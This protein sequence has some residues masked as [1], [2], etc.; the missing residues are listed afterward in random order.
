MDKVIIRNLKE[1]DEK[2]LML[3]YNSLVKE[4]A[5]TVAVRKVSFK[6]EREYVLKSVEDQKKKL[7]VDLVLEIN[8]RVVGVAG[9]EVKNREI[10]NHVGN[11]GIL[12]KKE[13]RGKGFG[14]KLSSSV[15]SEAKKK[16]K[17]KMVRLNVSHRNK[18][19]IKLY[20]KLGFKYVGTIKKGL[21]FFGR[22]D[23]DVLMVKHF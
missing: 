9:V 12:L 2:D 22:Y 23:D 18:I 13:A 19:A 7:V 15:I 4:K 17:I 20:E 11:F 16:L 8:G 5:M 6:K 1:G 21:N 14:F 10:T 3:L